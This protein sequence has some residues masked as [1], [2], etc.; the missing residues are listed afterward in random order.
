MKAENF[1]ELTDKKILNKIKNLKTNKLIDAAIVGL[2]IGIVIYS[3]VKHGF[4]FFTFF[5]LLLTY[6][7]VR[8]SKNNKILE[9]ELQKVIE[10][11]NTK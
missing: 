8:N 5:P 3:V 4:G 1:A 2:T 10:S 11:R 9:A 7:I 6:M